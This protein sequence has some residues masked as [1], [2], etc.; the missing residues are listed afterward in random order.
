M[1][2][3]HHRPSSKLTRAPLPPNNHPTL[4]KLQ[5]NIPL[6]SPISSNPTIIIKDL[7]NVN[8]LNE[9]YNFD[10]NRIHVQETVEIL[11][12]PV[13]CERIFYSYIDNHTNLRTKEYIKLD[14]DYYLSS[15]NSEE[16]I[17]YDHRFKLNIYS[18]TLFIFPKQRHEKFISEIHYIP[19]H[20]SI[21][22]KTSLELLASHE[23]YYQ[24]LHDFYHI[25]KDIF[26]RI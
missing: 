26:Y 16:Y 6:N 7:R 3:G 1:A 4:N 20:I 19:E 23:H 12:Q 10:N 24:N 22:Y 18:T 14:Q 21:K 11:P 13:S 9:I 8:L 2:S 17:E 15:K 25:A 5:S